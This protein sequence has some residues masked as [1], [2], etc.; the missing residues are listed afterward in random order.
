MPLFVKGGYDIVKIVD[1][2]SK[3]CEG[4]GKLYICP[5]CY[6]VVHST[7]V[8]EMLRV[9]TSYKLELV[10]KSPDFNYG[11]GAK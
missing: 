3:I 2:D 1:D 8:G 5:H 4:K 11:E 7:G 6:R 9:D 10:K